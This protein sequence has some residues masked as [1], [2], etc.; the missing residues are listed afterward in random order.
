MNRHP[1][2][3]HLQRCL[4][5]HQLAVVLVVGLLNRHDLVLVVYGRRSSTPHLLILPIAMIPILLEAP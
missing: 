4:I 3:H 2:A 5:L 1:P